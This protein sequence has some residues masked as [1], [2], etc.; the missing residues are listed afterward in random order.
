M[1][2]EKWRLP[3]MPDRKEREQES[4][5]ELDEPSPQS[6]KKRPGI[7]R[8]FERMRKVD[9]QQSKNYKQRTGE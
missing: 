5:R 9:P 1:L 4:E 2:L 8:L 6:N 3:R 7:D